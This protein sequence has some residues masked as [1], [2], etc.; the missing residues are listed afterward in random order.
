VPLDENSDN[1]GACGHGCLGGTC[2]RGICQPVIIAGST[3]QYTGLKSLYGMTIN[4]NLYGT[5]WYQATYGLVY[6]IPTT[7]FTMVAPFIVPVPANS[8]GSGVGM[9]NDGSKI[10][11]MSFR[12]QAGANTSRLY[13]ANLDGSSPTTLYTLGY[14]VDRVDVDASYLYWWLHGA[15]TYYVGD[16]A[17]T[18]VTTGTLDATSTLVSD[19]AG[20]VYYGSG[21]VVVKSPGNMPGTKTS[22]GA[23]GGVPNLIQIDGTYAYWLDAGTHKLWRAPRAGG[24]PVT[25]VTPVGGLPSAHS[26]TELVVDLLGPYVFVFDFEVAG[27]GDV[28]VIYR[29]PKDG[30]GP[31]VKVAD[32]PDGPGSITQDSTAIYWGSYGSDALP[33]HSPPTSAVYKLAK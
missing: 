31:A 7:G 17:G 25:E 11:Y 33:V 8:D 28:G 3:S 15:T 22:L 30:S 32:L 18:L 27:N 24:G 6:R 10:F 19:H 5:D 29:A 14:A 1:C 26:N 4:G 9:T 12:S 16:K 20:T 13:S 21:G 2:A 23:G